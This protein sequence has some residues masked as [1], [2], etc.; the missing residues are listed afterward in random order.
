MAVYR[1]P[2]CEQVVGRN[3]KRCI[4]CGLNFDLNHEPVLTEGNADSTE[5]SKNEKRKAVIFA[6]IA[7]IVILALFVFYY[8]NQRASWRIDGLI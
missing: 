6:V 7:V 1:C 2:K 8:I 4:N 3:A 5:L